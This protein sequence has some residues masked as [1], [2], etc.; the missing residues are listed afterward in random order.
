[1]GAILP[2]LEAIALNPAVDS[3][4]AG[5]LSAF[6]TNMINNSGATSELKQ[7]GNNLAGQ[8]PQIVKA[9]IANTPAAA[10]AAHS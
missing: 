10:V 6:A 2:A 3:A 5:W 7:I 1:M 4:L 8:I 9:V